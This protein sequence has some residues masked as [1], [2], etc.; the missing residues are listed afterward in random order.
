[1]RSRRHRL[2]LPGRCLD[3]RSSATADIRIT[4]WESDLI[5]NGGGRGGGVRESA[6]GRFW[7]STE[8]W[9]TCVCVWWGGEGGSGDVWRG[10]R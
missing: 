5:P 3:A 9:F 10:W 2:G 1:M 8:R 6:G 7:G 4:D